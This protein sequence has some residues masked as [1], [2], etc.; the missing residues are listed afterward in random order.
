MT[1][2]ARKQARARAE[3]MDKIRKELRNG[4]ITKAQLKNKA[5]VKVAKK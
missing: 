5:K 4:T 2:Q 3:H 1:P